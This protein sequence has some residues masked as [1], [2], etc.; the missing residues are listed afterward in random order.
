MSSQLL[1]CVQSSLAEGQNCQFVKA[2]LQLKCL[3]FQWLSLPMGHRNW[4]SESNKHQAYI[5]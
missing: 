4:I 1:K 2:K 5:N 3:K